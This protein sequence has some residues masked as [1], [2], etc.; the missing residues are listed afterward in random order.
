[1]DVESGEAGKGMEQNRG[2]NTALDLLSAHEA[3]NSQLKFKDVKFAVA[4]AGRASRGTKQIMHGVSGSV[5]SG[6]VLAIMV[7]PGPCRILPA[8]STNALCTLVS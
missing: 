7:G 1:M 5:N 3:A 8:T 6:E 4:S 2:S